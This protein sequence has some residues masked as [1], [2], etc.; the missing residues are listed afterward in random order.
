MDA[1]EIKA[2][3]ADKSLLVEALKEAGAEF[4]GDRIACPFH[5]DAHPS[6]G[7]FPATD[8]T[9]KFRCF[10]SCDFCGDVIDVVQ[11]HRG[12]DF[13]QALELLS[14]DGRGPVV[15][16][17]AKGSDGQQTT[18]P[19]K[20]YANLDDAIKAA[21]GPLQREH[22][23]GTHRLYTY[24]DGYRRLRYDWSNGKTF[25]EISKN[26][27]EWMLR[28]PK[29]KTPLYRI[30]EVSLTGVVYITE[31]E[32]AADA[33]RKIGL[34]CTTSGGT[35]SAASADWAPLA[36]RDVCILPDNDSPGEKYAQ[37][38]AEKL[39][40]LDPPAK[41]RLVRFRGERPGYDIADF[42]DDHDSLETDDLRKR[43]MSLAGEGAESTGRVEVETHY[44]DM[45]NASRLA[46]RFGDRIRW[47]K[48]L[49]WLIFD[50]RRWALDDTGA[51]V[52]LA[53]QTILG[54]CQRR[55]ESGVDLPV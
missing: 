29:G 47:T 35:S 53:T 37:A 24:A 5:E 36:G 55:S 33:G 6:G 42:I 26:G 25:R 51:V 12:C 41:A 17:S 21:L 11:Q 50:G 23:D 19:P 8:G 20:T 27:S 30:G 49:G 44:T 28:K 39:S 40:K 54:L 13:K 2:L 1:T 48:G 7:I 14:G 9:W 22:P 46:Q 16:V 31:G 43:I 34:Q 10:S 3:K 15:H 32:K 4:S 18:K 38:V 52:R 45:G